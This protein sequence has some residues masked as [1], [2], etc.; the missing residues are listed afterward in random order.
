MEKKEP[1]VSVIMTTYNHE[2]YIGDA[3][4]S[5]LRQTFSDLELVIVNDGSTDAT[6]ER[7]RAYHDPRIVYVQQENQGPSAAANRA[8]ATAR[9]KYISFMSGD[10]AC[11]PERLRLQVEE[12]SRLGRGILFSKAAFI[13]D[14]GRPTSGEVY[15]TNLRDVSSRGEALRSLFNGQCCFFTLTEFTEL[16]ILREMGPF[17]LMYYQ[18][19]DVDMLIRIL[20]KYGFRVMPETLYHFRIRNG[21]GNLSAP[22]PLKIVRTTNEF[23]LLM[24]HFFEGMSV[25]LFR[26]TFGD[27]LLH[28]DFR[29][30]DEF[31]CEQAYAYLRS[32]VPLIRIIGM[33]RLHHLLCDPGAAH[34]LKDRYQLT[35]VAYAELLKS[36][37]PTRLFPHES[38]HLY[39]DAGGGFNERQKL[40][41]RFLPGEKRDFRLTF[42]LSA[43]P[44]VRSLR[45]D[46]M[47]GQIC[48]VRIASLSYVDTAGVRHDVDPDV[49]HS[50]GILSRDGVVG[51][52]TTDPMFFLPI[53]GKIAALTIE[54]EWDVVSKETLIHAYRAHYW[55]QSL[56]SR[57]RFARACSKAR[58]A[59]RIWRTDG[60]GGVYQ[61][62]FR[63]FFAGRTD[64][65]TEESTERR[66]P[67]KRIGDAA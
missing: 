43:F 27:S 1:V 20:K 60:Y 61:K 57:S 33:E 34:V 13:D 55:P 10:D 32:P 26:E 38:T 47:E 21:M 67:G 28:A 11:P 66:T 46:P 6:D 54:G 51:F 5:I 15:A 42:D 64:A 40:S 29:A 17:D 8:I 35:P 48:Q 3:I 30:G 14:D 56:P 18:Y 4:D 31:H 45:W 59:M 58:R 62:L 50:N 25:E 2:K 37:D 12:Y 52:S 63:R 49:V 44:S 9:G 23:Y 53:Q 19:Q 65:A 22:D 24:R 7:I 39:I 16:G 36:I 41:A